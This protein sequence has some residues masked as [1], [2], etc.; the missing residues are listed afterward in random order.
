M[1]TPFYHLV[2]AQD[3]LCDERL[4]ADV[5]DLL[6]TERP[7]FLFGNTA[8]DVQTVS[9]Q[10]REETHF[11]SIQ[12]PELFPAQQVMF[13]KYPELANGA[14]LPAQQ[15]SFI[16]GYSMHLLVDQTWI[17][18]VFHPVFGSRALWKDFPERLF[19][20]NVLRAYLDQ[21]DYARLPVDMEGLLLANRSGC[22]LPFVRS[23]HLHLWRDFLAE[24]CAPGALV[25][26][27]EVFAERMGR[28]PE[29]FEYLLRSE[30]SIQD[31]ILSRMEP[32]A[33]E[34][35]RKSALVRSIATLNDYLSWDSERV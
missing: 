20:H 8:P 6:L 21:R 29:E 31:H 14:M 19:L 5:R 30:D 7:A 9:G 34:K 24:Q 4:H 11:F 2:M 33:L 25:R 35:F 12:S 28:K 32:Q 18:E 23:K 13:G 22:W 17:R 1:P 27:V 26:T 16:A 3:M 15:A 10:E